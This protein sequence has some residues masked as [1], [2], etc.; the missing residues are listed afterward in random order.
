MQPNT[1]YDEDEDE[2]F[3]VNRATNGQQD[4]ISDGSS[5]KKGYNNQSKQLATRGSKSNV[6]TRQDSGSDVSNEGKS[7]DNRSKQIA[8]DYSGQGQ[9][10]TLNNVRSSEQSGGNAS[11]SDAG[12][13]EEDEENGLY[14]GG[15]GKKKK[16]FWNR[17]RAIMGGGISGTVVLAGLFGGSFL[18]GPLEFVHFSQLMQEFHLNQQSDDS[19]MRLGMLARYAK[20]YTVDRGKG[21]LERTRLGFFA[22][23]IADKVEAQL[24]KGGITSVYDKAGNFR[25]YSIDPTATGQDADS[26]KDQYKTDYGITLTDDPDNP[27]KLFAASDSSYNSVS[28]Y[29]ANRSL[30]QSAMKETDLKGVTGAI[31]RHIV[32]KRAGLSFHPLSDLDTNVS[33]KLVD[34]YN[35]L[36]AN[37]DETIEDG[38]QDDPLASTAGSDTEDANGQP[39]PPDANASS[40]TAAA[41]AGEQAAQQAESGVDQAGTKAAQAA[42]S[43]FLNSLKGGAGGAAA[44]TGVVCALYELNEEGAKIKQAQVILPLMRMAF[45]VVSLGSQVMN[46]KDVNFSELGYYATF[47]YNTQTKSSW[48]GARS[49]QTETGEKVT[50]PTVDE[51]LTTLG[52]TKTPLSFI[53]NSAVRTVCNKAVQVGLSIL[54]FIGGPFTFLGQQVISKYI[55]EPLV[56]ESGVLDDVI[57]WVA[58]KALDPDSFIGAP[59]G[60]AVNYGSELVENDSFIAAGG[61]ALTPAQTS[62]QDQDQ[63]AETNQ[64][65]RQQSFF[66]RIFSPTDSKSILGSIIDTQ[67]PVLASNIE[68]TASG[69]AGIAGSIFSLPS[70]LAGM[71]S[72][73]VSA[74]GA[75]QSAPYNYGFPTYGFSD[76]DLSNPLVQDPYKNADAVL[77]MLDGQNG[78]DAGKVMEAAHTCFNVTL[79]SAGDV[80]PI[81]QEGD[82]ISQTFSKYPTGGCADGTEA[83]LSTSQWLQVRMYIFDTEDADSASCLYGDDSSCS[84]VGFTDGGDADGSSGS[85]TP[86]TSAGAPTYCQNGTATGN[87]KIVCSAWLFDNFGYGNVIRGDAS[88]M[89]K[90]MT[91]VRTCDANSFGTGCVYTKYEALVDCSGLVDAAVY[92]GTGVDLDGDDTQE[93]PSN[94]HLQAIPISEAQP[95]D[96]AWWGDATH[97]HTEVIV[98]YNATTGTLSTFGAHDSNVAGPDQIDAATYPTPYFPAPDKIFRVVQ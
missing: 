70:K 7:Y 12:S 87:E 22:N 1:V 95:G 66:A 50:G 32:G 76:A 97:Q 10:N 29:L 54:T 64:E 2:K 23:N 21:G 40:E 8:S 85:S 63:Q 25:G 48:A 33:E 69:F 96:I 39:V 86:V 11:A 16:G 46:G 35:K 55:V 93:Y 38:V 17:R 91:N 89:Q 26:I 31:M 4:S 18:S 74:D 83:G 65:F 73:V 49:V 34:Y 90:L 60:D 24:N 53:D 52:S 79:D 61:T 9:E 67:N 37:R 45:E 71:V 20:L 80:T 15:G 44:A 27:G 47:L 98:S 88:V 77:D 28:N 36:K 78:V 94:S 58:G 81:G 41:T 62:E 14:K 13:P 72:S 82:S 84:N 75:T 57:H 56:A 43:G 59:F 30:I 6:N 51:T 42:E 19:D 3:G 92:D 68:Q 5:P